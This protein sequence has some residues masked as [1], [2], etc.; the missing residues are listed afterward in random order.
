M[1][2]S[3]NWRDRPARAEGDQGGS[4]GWRTGGQQRREPRAP[5]AERSRSD[6]SQAKRSGPQQDDPATAQSIAEG[7]RIYLGNLVYQATPEDVEELLA[8]NDLQAANIHISIDPMTRRNPG[9][10]F[11]EFTDKETAD[12]AMAT[13]EG[14]LVL[15]REVKSRP[16]QPKA[17]GRRRPRD[18]TGGQAFNRWGD[19]TGP[20]DAEQEDGPVKN[21]AGRSGP[22]DAIKYFNS[23]ESEGRQVYIGG[24]PKMLD[25]PTNDEEMRE[26][27]KGYDV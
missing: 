4:R 21:L 18:T 24:L 17:D 1:S 12:A 9:Y 6:D 20:R 2:E 14:K 26:I 13:L 22:Y 8:A 19:W 10:C 27:F 23:S 3:Q 5:F 15:G 7:R 11:I 25:Q 16:C